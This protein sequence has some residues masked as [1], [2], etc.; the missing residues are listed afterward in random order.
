M[1]TM[2][3]N[4]SRIRELQSLSVN[5]SD[6]CQSHKHQILPRALTK[7]SIMAITNVQYARAKCGGTP[8]SGRA[9]HA[10]QSFIC[11]ALRSGPQIKVPLYIR[12]NLRTGI[13]RRF[14]NGG[15]QAVTF[16]KMSCQPRTPAGARRRQIRVPRLA[17]R[18]IHVDRPVAKNASVRVHILVS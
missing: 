14:D 8:R 15:V 2:S 10:G 4:N 12:V 18:H 7:T 5:P 13:C 16:P 6:A 11:S 1:F 9:T 3:H 17:F